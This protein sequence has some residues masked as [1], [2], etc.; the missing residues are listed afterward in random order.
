MIIMSAG[1][2]SVSDRVKNAFNSESTNPDLDPNY[3]KLHLN[4]TKKYSR[5]LNTNCS[6]FI[7]LGE[8]MLGLD[9]ACASV[10]ESGDRV[11][12][13]SNGIFGS[14]FESMARAYGA[15][16]VLYE[17]DFR[18]GIDIKHLESFLKK[19]HDFKAATLV[20]CET[21][22][23]ITNDIEGI[24]NIL[25]SYGI[26][27]IVDSVSGILGNY[28]DFDKFKID[29]LIGGT[30]KCISAPPGLTLITLSD[31]LKKYIES[32]DNI[33]GYYANFK[34]YLSTVEDFDFPYTMNDSLTKA[35]N[36]A[37]DEAIESNYVV[38][39]REDATKTRLGL[40]DAGLEL[41]ALSYPSDTVSCFSLNNNI[42]SKTILDKM[43]NR[44]YIISGSFGHLKD[45]AIR[46]GHMGNNISENN[47]DNFISMLKNL[48]EVM[49][50]SGVI[51]HDKIY[52]YFL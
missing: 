35:L 5:A 24:C 22:T 18:H 11:L 40:Y 39:H 49:E 32:R 16:T 27:S 14:G 33:A 4:L 38:R 17:S 29:C 34:N 48:Q 42:K 25:N 37:I 8:A 3:T 21:P 36:E 10:I 19:D 7:M 44:G 51:L 20:H 9:G 45:N 15:D 28:I 23:G 6:S 52:K 31:N 30:Q 43:M 13:I 12:I 26:Y 47:K 1:P 50:E 2:T 46:I 41:Y